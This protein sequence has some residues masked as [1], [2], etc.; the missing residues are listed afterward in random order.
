M[1]NSVSMPAKPLARVPMGW[2]CQAEKFSICT[3]D[4]QPVVKPQGYPAAWVFMAAASSS[5]QVFG[6]S[7]TPALANAVLL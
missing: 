2:L 5:G 7:A 4:C 6:A 3:Q 1:T